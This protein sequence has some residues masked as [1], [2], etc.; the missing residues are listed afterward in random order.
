MNLSLKLWRVVPLSLSHDPVGFIN[1]RSRPSQ[2]CFFPSTLYKLI[3]ENNFCV[4][5]TSTFFVF[6]QS[7]VQI[8]VAMFYQLTDVTIV[9]F[10]LLRFCPRERE[11]CVDSG[12]CFSPR[13]P[14]RTF[15]LLRAGCFLGY[16]WWIRGKQS[17]CE[18]SGCYPLGFGPGAGNGVV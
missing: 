14:R 1:K 6:F 5:L 12:S 2:Y 10:T 16:A 13:L 18:R 7:S 15:P 8:S 9:F 4:L 3:K 17:K 11:P